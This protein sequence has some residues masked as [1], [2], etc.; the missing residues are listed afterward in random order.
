MD[1][2]T[3]SL[4]DANYC[5]PYGSTPPSLSISRR[6]IYD[7]QWEKREGG[8][9]RREKKE[10]KVLNFESQRRGEG[11]GVGKESCSPPYD[12]GLKAIHICMVIIKGHHSH[13]PH[14]HMCVCAYMDI[15]LFKSSIR[16]TKRQAWDL[17]GPLCACH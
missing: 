2:Y 16:W 17:I 10:L 1:E 15:M 11:R 14:T 6:Y 3:I 5:R 13:S 7:K 8:R 12:V 4:Q 9:K